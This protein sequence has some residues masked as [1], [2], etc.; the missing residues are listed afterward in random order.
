MEIVNS[1][2][3]KTRLSQLI[4]RALAGER[5]VIAR[6]GK[7]LVELRPYREQERR[8]GGVWKGRVRMASD[9][10]EP[11]AELEREIYGDTPPA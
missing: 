4:R 7:P 9:F 1:Y 8:Q 6:A 5:I 11:L 3:A 2:E 10:D